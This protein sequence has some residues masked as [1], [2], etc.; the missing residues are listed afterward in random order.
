M[1][2]SNRVSD[3]LGGRTLLLSQVLNK[4]IGGG[5]YY[6]EKGEVIKVHDKYVAEIELLRSG[7]ILKLDQQDLEVSKACQ[8]P[9]CARVR[10]CVC[11]CPVCACEYCVPVRAKSACVFAR[12]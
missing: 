7:D 2:E 3:T 8:A 10:V 5:Q 11:L 4:R 9:V 12:K 1:S 6:K